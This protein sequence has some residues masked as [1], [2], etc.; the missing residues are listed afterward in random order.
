[1]K[2]WSKIVSPGKSAHA[3]KIG[4][5]LLFWTIAYLFFISFFGRANRDYRSTLVFASMLFPVAIATSYFLNYYLIPRFLFTK[6]YFRFALFLFYTLVITSWIETMISMFTLII[7]SDYQISRMDP[8][9][10]DLVFMLVG[11]YFI[12]L[13]AGSIKIIQNTFEIKQQNKQLDEL[14]F[15]AELRLKEAE[16]KL[17]RAQ[18][19]PHF[20]FNTL[21]NLY[22]LTLE[23]SE[24]APEL[25]LKLA[26][27]MDYMLYRC[28]QPRVPLGNEI[29]HLGNYIEIERLR[30]DGNLD[31]QFTSEGKTEKLFIA[32]MLLLPL[33]ENAFKHG[34]SKSIDQPFV[35]IQLSVNDHELSLHVKNSCPL[36]NSQEEVYSRGI[37]IQN[38]QKRLQLIYPNKHTITY[39]QEGSIYMASLQIELE[40]NKDI[41]ENKTQ[42]Q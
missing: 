32:P 14:R 38:L 40:N 30:Y 31:L 19:H 4:R 10:F 15:Q 35:N 3:L 18:I 7:V 27:L 42:E 24:L 12:I 34:V 20:L 36:N 9:S 11:F 26:D 5:H 25:V 8:A 2:G 22:G 1:M 16:L 37:G 41:T 23:K 39:A 33:V 28:N 13:G 17:L 21:N 6:R 29:L